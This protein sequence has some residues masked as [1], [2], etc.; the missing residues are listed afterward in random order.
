MD[1][2][3]QEVT[4]SAKTT[5]HRTVMVE[6]TDVKLTLGEAQTF[7]TRQDQ[8]EGIHY[9]TQGGRRGDPVVQR[10]G[11]QIERSGFEPRPDH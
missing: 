2:T 7:C 10:T 5:W 1:T 3:W 9:V 8:M 11:H 6:F 4:W